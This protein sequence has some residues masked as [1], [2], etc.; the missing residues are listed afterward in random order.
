MQPPILYGQLKSPVYTYL[1]IFWTK[2][3]N[4][5]SQRKSIPRPQN[6]ELVSSVRKKKINLTCVRR[7]Q[8]MLWWAGGEWGLEARP[9]GLCGYFYSCEME[10]KFRTRLFT[11]VFSGTYNAINKR[12]R[13]NYLRLCCVDL[14]H[15]TLRFQELMELPGEIGW[16]VTSS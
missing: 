8:G 6:N 15:G 16:V 9:G 5:K 4:P 3:L 14:V 13:V 2:L 12:G 1:N 7:G 10:E 11:T